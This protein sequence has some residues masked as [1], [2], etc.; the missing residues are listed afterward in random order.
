MSY[1]PLIAVVAYH[2]DDTRVARWPDGGYGVPGALHRCASARRRTHRDRLARA[3]TASP[4]RS[5]SR[6]TACCSSA[7]ATSIRRATVP[8]PTP[9]TTTASSPT[10]TRSRSRCSSRR[11]D[12]HMPT[13]CICRGMQVMNVAFGGTLHQHL[14]DHDGLLAHGVPLEGTETMHDVEP[15]PGSRLAATTKSGPLRCSLAPP[16]GARPDRRRARGRR[17]EPRRARG[18]ARAASWP[19][20]KKSGRRGCSACSGTPRRRADTDAGQQSL[21][22]A[23]VIIARLHGDGRGPASPKAVP[24]STHSPT[25]TPAG[26]SAFDRAAAE[27]RVILGDVVDRIDHVGSTSVPGL[28]AKPVIDVQVSV[29]SMVPR[30]AYVDPL[31]AAG[32][33]LGAR[34]VGR[35]PRVL[36]PRP[37]RRAL[38][39]RPRVPR[40]AAM[41]AASPRVPR[42][43]PRPPR[44]RRA[45]GG[46]QTRIG[47]PPTRATSTATRT[48]RASSSATSRP[49][50]RPRARAGGLALPRHLGDDARLQ[51]CPTG[52]IAAQGRS[53][54]DFYGR[55]PVAP[56]TL[57]RHT[58]GSAVTE[59]AAT[60]F[61]SR[62]PTEA[63][64]GVM[65][66]SGPYFN[67]SDIERPL[68]WWRERGYTVKLADSVWA[69]DDYVAGPPEK[70]AEDLNGAVRRPRGRR[71]PGALG[72]H[73]RHRDRCRSSTM[74]LIARNPKA[75]MG[76]SDITN[77]HVALR[78]DA[79]LATLHGPGFGSMG[80]PERNGRS[81]G[82]PRSPRFEGATGP[83]PRRPRRPVRAHDRRRP[84]QRRRSSAATSSPSST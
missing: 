57:R 51:A 19:I 35:H 63:R 17:P 27:L 54:H 6:S 16:P 8:S 20:S 52:R 30:S 1:R 18:G 21:F 24:A 83:V 67:R 11:T 45:Y 61:G 29:R 22:D 3:R 42:L 73:R 14:P 44:R 28:A 70:R 66:P 74:D 77:L 49:A 55:D 62:C 43:A 69:K 60:R 7:A 4:P 84:R 39:A 2:L 36:L 59:V 50:P 58:H 26:R 31:V 10:A 81:R 5:S 41:G 40:R 56:E 34:S 37:G 48:G 64:S 72:R 53:D 65:A 38:R 75:L 23:L 80:I 79:G 32:F 71:D 25:P 9:R 46:P 78:Q 68:A 76:Y 82:T 47:W 33:R 13:L 15:E 12:R